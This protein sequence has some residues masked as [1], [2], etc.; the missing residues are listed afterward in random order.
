[1]PVDEVSHAGLE[2]NLRADDATYTVKS[3]WICTTLPR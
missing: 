1:M 2:K 3:L